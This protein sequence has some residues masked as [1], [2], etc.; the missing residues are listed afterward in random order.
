VERFVVSYDIW[1]EDKFSVTMPGPANRSAS[2]LSASA[3]EAWCLEGLAISASGIAPDRPFWLRLDMRT[4]DQKDLASVLADP[5][6]SLRNIILLLGRKPGAGDPQWTREAGPL[7][8]ADL[9]RAAARGA[10]SG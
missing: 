4:A 3:A 10:R 7:R 9:A 5:G 6:I 2:N 1:G 8:L